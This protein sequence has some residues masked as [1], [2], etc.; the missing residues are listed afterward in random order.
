MTGLVLAGIAAGLGAALFQALSYFFS[1]RFLTECNA[2][3]RMLFSISLV[4]MAVASAVALPFL[5]SRPLP[6][7]SSF[8]WPLAGTA[9]FFM[10][11]QWLLFTLLKTTDSSVVAPLLGLKIPMLGILSVF[12]LGEDIPPVAWLAILMCPVAALMISPPRGLPQIRTLILI[13][14]ICLLYS[15]SDLHIP[16][17]VERVADASAMP[18]LLAVAMTYVLCGLIGLA[19]ALQ[20]GAFKIKNGQR[21]ALPYSF[22]WLAGMCFLF[23]AFSLIGVIFGNMLQSTR[24]FISVIVG[25]MLSSYGLNHLEARI[26]A[27]S[28]LVRGAGAL[29]MTTAIIIYYTVSL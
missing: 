3:S 29:L 22:C 6:P 19:M 15:G 16:V 23:I 9:G 17:L 1:R 5:L 11:A 4:Q 24:G 2:G 25:A 18:A 7:W 13:L 8:A 10:A 28:W 14:I 21:Y 12:L 27:R 26:P 20:Q